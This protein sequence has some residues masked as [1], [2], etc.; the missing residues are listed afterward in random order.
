MTKIKG[1]T[2]NIGYTYK[3]CP[4]STWYKENYY[5]NGFLGNSTNPNL[6]VVTGDH[7]D[8]DG[9]MNMH[10]RGGLPGWCCWDDNC[11]YFITYGIR[12]FES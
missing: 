7:P 4:F 8:T 3:R 2:P 11:P 10:N 12:Y 1:H 5:D 9:T 6:P